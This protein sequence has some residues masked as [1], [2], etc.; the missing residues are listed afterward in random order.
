LLTL[1]GFVT[2]ENFSQLLLFSSVTQLGDMERSEK[3]F[4]EA[5]HQPLLLC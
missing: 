2:F 3:V 4:K 5:S 1:T